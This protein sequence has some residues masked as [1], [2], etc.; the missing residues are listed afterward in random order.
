M[1]KNI[2][3]GI[4]VFL[5]IVL[6]YFAMKGKSGVQEAATIKSQDT[7]SLQKEVAAN[8]SLMVSKGGSITAL[9]GASQSKISQAIQ[10]VVSATVPAGSVNRPYTCYL[11]GSG[12]AVV[13]QFETQG[14]YGI[15]WHP[16][17]NVFC[18]AN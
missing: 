12:D 9:S 7:I 17:A 14:N 16:L 18:F 3:I 2:V 1:N 4:L 5:V 15:A 11:T 6:G 10:T 8:Q 13:F